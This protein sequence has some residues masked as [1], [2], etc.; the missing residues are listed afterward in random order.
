MKRENASFWEIKEEIRVLG[1]D[2]GPFSFGAGQEALVVGTL[3]RGGLWLDGVLTTHVTVDG[4]DAT[5]KLVDMINRSRHRGQMRVVMTDGLTLGGFNVIDGNE[6]F[7]RTG[8]PVISVTRSLPDMRAI[9]DALVKLPHYDRRWRVIRQ[10]GKP[11]QHT[12]PDGRGSGK[13]F[14]QAFGAEEADA[15]AIIEVT[16]TRSLMPEP[17]RVAHIIA[18]GIVKGES[19]G[20]V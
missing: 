2:D 8:L 20:R 18:S 9:K 17:I 7:E 10:A 12:Y 16:S 19:Y 14:F 1:V 6:I 13:V 4:E 15:H 3:F 5:D 11:K